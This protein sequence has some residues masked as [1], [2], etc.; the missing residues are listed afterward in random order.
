VSVLLLEAEAAACS[1][2]VVAVGVAPPGVG[3]GVRP[4]A[5]WHDAGPWA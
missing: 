1:R 3:A 5:D 2:I 4:L